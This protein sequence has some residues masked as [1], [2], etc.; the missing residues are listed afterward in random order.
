M[1]GTLLESV[2]PMATDDLIGRERGMGVA[3]EHHLDRDIVRD[4]YT[5]NQK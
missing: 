3:I 4:I 2:Y 1:T 5:M